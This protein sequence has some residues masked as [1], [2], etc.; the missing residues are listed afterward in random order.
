MSTRF[1]TDAHLRY[2]L[3]TDAAVFVVG[4]LLVILASR[5]RSLVSPLAAWLLLAALVVGFAVEITLWLLRGVRRVEVDENTLTLTVGRRRKIQSV[6]RQDIA[7]MQVSRHLGRTALLVKLKT[8][9]RLRIPEDAFPR[10]AFAQLLSALE[11]W[12]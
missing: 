11:G 5:L 4:A 8:G 12:N 3:F 9:A 10:E 1:S 6:E 2:V 7:R